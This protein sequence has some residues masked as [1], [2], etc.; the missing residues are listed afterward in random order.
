MTDV[1]EKRNIIQEEEVK[2]NSS[3]SE[4][5]LFRVGATA[6]F[7]SKKQYDTHAFHLNGVYSAFLNV[8]GAD[9]IFPC[10]FNLEIIGITIYNRVAGTSG[11]TEFDLKWYNAPGSA[12]GSLFS[13]KPS[14][15]SS[16]GSNAYLIYDALN[17][18]TI[19]APGSGSVSPV[20]S[21]TNFDAGDAIFFELTS[22]MSGGQDATIEVHFRPR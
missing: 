17:T 10:L 11:T 15:D 3:V 8:L 7:I 22:S 13:T 9:G 6:N 2:F 16:S 1:T 12:Q 19:A 18:N 14:F 20:L 5:T 21:K 4:A